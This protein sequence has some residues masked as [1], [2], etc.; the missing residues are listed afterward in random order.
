MLGLARKNLF[1]CHLHNLIPNFSDKM[2][3]RSLQIVTVA[4]IVKVCRGSGKVND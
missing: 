2:I 1:Q 4:L 3:I